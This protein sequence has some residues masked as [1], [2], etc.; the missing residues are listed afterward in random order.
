LSLKYY[1]V[2]QKLARKNI[3]NYSRK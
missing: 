1:K 3:N 2:S